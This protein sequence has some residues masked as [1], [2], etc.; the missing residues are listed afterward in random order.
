MQIDGAANV[1]LVS[2]GSPERPRRRFA[3]SYGS[4][5][6]YFVV[7]RVILFRIGHDRRSLVPRVDFVS[8]PGTS[9][10]GVYRTGG[11]VALVTERCRF[12][13][14]ATRGRFR[15]ETLHPGHTLE[16]V[17]DETGFDFDLPEDGT[18]AT[19]PLLGP[20]ALAALRGPVAAALAE[21]Y[22]AFSKRVLGAGAVSETTSP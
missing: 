19:T 10:P 8:A 18:P 7:P 6:L 5:Y 4:A 13:F 2:L 9:P 17:R 1:N 14:D 3:G 21:V 22:P 12:A 11:P 16:E 20:L 15:L